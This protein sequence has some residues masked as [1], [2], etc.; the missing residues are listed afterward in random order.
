M[1]I[2]R[3][4]VIR[5]TA[6]SPLFMPALS[7]GRILGAND[8]LNMAV[9]GTGG[10]G[11]GHL[12]SLVKRSDEENIDVIR[13]CDVYRRRLDNS[14]KV[15]SLAA[16][17]A[18]ME[19]ERVLDDPDV[20]A[21][22]IA[23]PDHWHTKIAIEAMEAGKDVYCEKPLSHTI[24]QAIACRDA[25]HR[26][27]RTLQVGP[28]GTSDGSFW[29]AGQAI[30]EGRIGKP[31][32]SQGAYCR[33]SRGG[34][35]NWHIDPD[36]GPQNTHDKAGY[37]WWDRW[38]GH[39]HGLAPKIDWNA[40]HFF[41]FR[42]YL[43]YNGGLATD[44]LYHRLAPLLLAI[45]GHDGAYPKRVV[46]SGGI[47]LEKDERDIADTFFMMVDYPTEHTIVLS[48]VMTNN[49]TWPTVI[50]GQYGTMEFGNGLTLSEQPPW[51]EEFRTANGVDITHEDGKPTPKPGT[52]TA[53]IDPMDRRDHMGNFLDA[54]RNGDRLACNVDLGCATMVAIK[55]AVDAWK[56]DQ[57]LL[58]NDEQEVVTRT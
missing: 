56:H 8:R 7:W 1:P 3:R 53:H 10:M 46:A 13:A 4:T 6:L 5:A 42:K 38:L 20:D 54:V 36:A 27:G 52:A 43:A 48:S 11:T 51:W 28:Q 44:L 35:F 30:R 47:Y 33:N 49:D 12:T 21:V 58:W 18:T 15:A 39:E 25:V 29:A 41:R 26:T 17:K 2:T 57:V 19:Y 16:G 31:T 40:D 22:V 24:P 50:R 23:T 14:A 45:E 32:W 37:V 55:M 9:I 34:Q